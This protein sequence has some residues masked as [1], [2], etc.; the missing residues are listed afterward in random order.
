MRVSKIINKTDK[1]V[2]PYLR[3][4]A[5]VV[6][7]S[8]KVTA[9]VRYV[10][11]DTWRWYSGYGGG[12]RVMIRMP[13]DEAFRPFEKQTLGYFRSHNIPL[14]KPYRI[15]N[16]WEL[17]VS[18]AAHEF[19]HCTPMGIQNRKSRIELFCE[20]KAAEAVELLRS[21]EGQA[22]IAEAQR[23]AQD[24]ASRVAAR[25]AYSKTAEFKLAQ[26]RLREKR[27]I[28]RTKRAATALKKIRRTIKRLEKKELDN[29]SAGSNNGQEVMH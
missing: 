2:E 21:P 5:K 15:D 17:L 1:D 26:L 27:W 11:R 16:W 24:R 28:T 18:I 12:N 14:R 8:K 4:A 20:Q 3:L 19:G 10:R 13:R 7:T 25:R 23:T 22:F 9:T 29:Q 6:N